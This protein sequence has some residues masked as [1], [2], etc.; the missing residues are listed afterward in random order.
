MEVDEWSRQEGGEERRREGRRG[1]TGGRGGGREKGGRERRETG[2]EGFKSVQSKMTRSET[3]QRDENMF[4]LRRRGLTRL[5]NVAHAYW[6]ER[7]VFI[8]CCFHSIEFRCFSRYHSSNN[9]INRADWKENWAEGKRTD[10]EKGWRRRLQED[11][12]L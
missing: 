11:W 10:E 4:T 3:M 5:V 2:T 1:G 6:G 9:H 7:D 12:C 8:F